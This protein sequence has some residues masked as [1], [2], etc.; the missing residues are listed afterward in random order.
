MRPMR[1]WTTAGLGRRRA[2]TFL[3]PVLSLEQFLWAWLY[4][5]AG[6]VSYCLELLSTLG[7]EAQRG[8]LGL[9]CSM[10]ADTFVAHGVANVKARLIGIK[11]GRSRVAGADRLMTPDDGQHTSALFPIPVG[12]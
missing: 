6:Q 12:S 2:E 4:C 1:A 7:V 10:S 8:R 5:F 3:M 11:V 9:W